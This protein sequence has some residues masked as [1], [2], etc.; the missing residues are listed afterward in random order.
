MGERGL[1]DSACVIYLQLE[2][3]FLR[4]NSAE[5]VSRSQRAEGAGIVVGRPPG[6]EVQSSLIMA[7]PKVVNKFT[8]AEIARHNT[9][10]DAWLLIHGKVMV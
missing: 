6:C 5:P 8:L 4:S 7:E 10:E 3:S 9:R 1:G 2:A